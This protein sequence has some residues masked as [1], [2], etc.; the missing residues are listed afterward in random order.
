MIIDSHQHFW[1]YDPVKSAWIDESMMEIRKDFVPSDLESILQKQNIDG[2]ITVQV[3]QTEEETLFMLKQAKKYS[4]IKSVVGWIDLR[5]DN[6]TGRLEYFSDFDHLAGFRHILQAE[7]PSRMLEPEFLRGISELKKYDFTYDI[8]IYP[9]HLD[10][11]IE[12][13]KK[14]PDQKFVIDHMAKPE[15]RN[16]TFEPWATK[17]AEMAEYDHVWCKVSGLITE[18]D[19]KNWTTDQLKPYLDH[20]FDRFGP[21]RIMYGSDWPVCLLAGSYDQVY[22]LIRDYVEDLSDSEKMDVLGNN[23][24]KFYGIDLQ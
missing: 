1:K 21:K 10:A 22:S 8:L 23:A 20:V 5:A 12:L 15:I 11:A 18:A 6:I 19:W 16:G 3:D 24:S 7:E 17:M 13:V 2:C 14:N 9:K 4:F